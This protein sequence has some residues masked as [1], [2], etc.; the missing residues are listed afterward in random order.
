MMGYFI[1][2]LFNKESENKL[3]SRKFICSY[4]CIVLMFLLEI[5]MVNY[6][7]IQK[8]IVITF[9]LYPLVFLT[10]IILIVHPMPTKE[11]YGEYCRGMANFMYY[12]HPI[13][14][15]SLKL[16]FK[17]ANTL[18]FILTTIITS[19]IGYAIVKLD[20]RFIN[21]LIY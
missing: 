1:N 2:T 19:A 20:N 15:L 21:K 4:I 8:D 18:I 13:F 14:I 9:F 10:V 6:F 17:D 7:K 16:I 11:M 12:S 5:I 3:F